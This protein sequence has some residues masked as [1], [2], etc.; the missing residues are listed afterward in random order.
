MICD[1]CILKTDVSHFL[2]AEWDEMIGPKLACHGGSLLFGVDSNELQGLVE[3]L[4][5][6]FMSI[7]GNNLTLNEPSHVILPIKYF[8]SMNLEAFLYFDA[9]KN[10]EQRSG[11]LLNMI[12]FL[13]NKICRDFEN[14][15]MNIITNEFKAHND[16]EEEKIELL[17]KIS[18]KLKAFHDT[19]KDTF[20]N[21][22]L[23][24]KANQS[25]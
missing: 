5:M 3:N 4:F 23:C 11:Q 24:D 12:V 9:K 15:Y 21:P 6:I 20:T 10:D 25:S 14:D 1:S 8:H 22:V 18:N 13:T 7:Y 16:E 17:K 19:K 2:L